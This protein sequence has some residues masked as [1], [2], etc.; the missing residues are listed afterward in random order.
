MIAKEN[1]HAWHDSV[2]SMKQDLDLEVGQVGE[3]VTVPG[4]LFGD[5]GDGE[6]RALAYRPRYATLLMEYEQQGGRFRL[7][8]RVAALQTD[9]DL[10]NWKGGAT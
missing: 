8:G 10:R 2:Q 1:R 5:L 3:A 7:T 9:Q 4:S 6:A